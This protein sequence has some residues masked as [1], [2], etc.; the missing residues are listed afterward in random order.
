MEGCDPG[1]NMENI[2]SGELPTLIFC[3]VVCQLAGVLGSVFTRSSVSTWYQTLTKPWF[4]PQ[5]W[6]ITTVWLVLFTLMGLSLFLVYREGLTR[7]DVR[8]ALGIFAVQLLVNVLWSMVF[9]GLRWPMGGLAI[10]AVLWFLIA[11][12]ILKFWAISREAALLLIP[13]LLWVCFAAFLNYS[14]WRLN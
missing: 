2:R 10:I 8:M 4:T 9:F 6:I 12:T 13:Y 1:D 3:I 5:G 7:V 11:L 14:I